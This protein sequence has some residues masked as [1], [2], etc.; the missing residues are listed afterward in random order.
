MVLTKRNY[1][2]HCQPLPQS[3]RNGQFF[4][5]FDVSHAVTPSSCCPAANFDFV[6]L[7]MVPFHLASYASSFTPWDIL[8]AIHYRPIFLAHV[9]RASSTCGMC[10]LQR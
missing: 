10:T 8:A 6:M 5:F 4:S 3:T 7:L 2:A 1:A 9:E